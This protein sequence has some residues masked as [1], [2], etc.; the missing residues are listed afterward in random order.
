MG[1]H[2]AFVFHYISDGRCIERWEL[3]KKDGLRF[4]S[5]YVYYLCHYRF[6]FLLLIKRHI[7]KAHRQMM[8]SLVFILV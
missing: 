8:M 2:L 5:L 1:K 3:I 7:N 4:Y 6:L